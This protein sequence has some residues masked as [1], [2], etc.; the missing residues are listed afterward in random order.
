[1]GSRT[2]VRLLKPNQA[3]IPY[4]D[5]QK[6]ESLRT[7]ITTRLADENIEMPPLLFFKHCLNRT[8]ALIADGKLDVRPTSPNFFL[9]GHTGPQILE[10]TINQ[11][12][13]ENR[14]ERDK[15]RTNALLK[16]MKKRPLA[17]EAQKQSVRDMIA[18]A[19]TPEAIA[20]AKAA[21]KG[22]K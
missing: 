11:L 21:R 2:L 18:K 13:G 8:D 4:P 16:E 19:S 3:V 17:S 1:M 14:A 7:R 12:R 15:A 10:Q 6:A 22:R 20:A 9:I 5:R